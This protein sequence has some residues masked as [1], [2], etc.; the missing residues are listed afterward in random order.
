MTIPIMF[1]V[2]IPRQGWLKVN[3]ICVAFDNKKIAKSTAR[4]VGNRARVE[5]IDKS[6]ENLEPYLLS[7]EAN[8]SKN[9]WR[10]WKS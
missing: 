6:L 3:N 10:I 7:V 1:G 5:F 4:R 9:T 8:R 2:W